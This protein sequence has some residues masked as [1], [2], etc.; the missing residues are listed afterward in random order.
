MTDYDKLGLKFITIIFFPIL[1]IIIFFNIFF[2]F[3]EKIK[4]E[5]KNNG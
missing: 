5:V 2:N 3:L 4:R 1:I